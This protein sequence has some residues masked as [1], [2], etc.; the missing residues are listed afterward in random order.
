MTRPLLLDVDTGVDDAIAIALA[1][2]LDDHKLVALTTVAGNV[3]V[4]FATNNTSCV[5]RWLGLDVPIYRGM[6]APLV[7]PLVDA[8]EHH[9]YDGLGGW[10]VP[11]QPGVPEATTA[12]EVIVELARRHQGNITFVFTGPLTNLAVALRLEPRICE[13]IDRLVIMGG[14]FFQPGNVT[15]HAEF[16]IFVDPEA[17]A[18]VAASSLPATWIGL[19]VTHQTTL[20]RQQWDAMANLADPVETLVREVT[21]QTLVDLGKPRFP[22]HDPLAVAVAERSAIVD[23]ETGE[24]VVDTSEVL[25]GR[26][27]LIAGAEGSHIARVGRTVDQKLFWSLFDRLVSLEVT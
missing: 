22:L 12:P 1:S 2:R 26:T 27:R 20:N 14:A 16:N 18:Q 15:P 24:V 10:H 9:G 7:R 23:I 11:V 19:D 8:R 17:A 3:P 5:A 21:R 6:S 13:W 4:D 25:R